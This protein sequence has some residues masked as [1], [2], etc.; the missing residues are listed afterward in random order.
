MQTLRDLLNSVQGRRFLETNGVYAIQ[1][2]FKAHLQ[3]PVNQKLAA[4]RGQDNKKL[5]CSG[6][7]IYVDYRQSVLSKIILLQELEREDD[8]YP[9]FLWVDTDR[10]GSDNL[11]TKLA[12][13]VYSKKGPIS[14]LPPRS[15]EIE[16]RFVVLDD[17]RLT[18]A[19]DKLETYLRQHSRHKKGAKER[20]LQLRSI[21]VEEDHP[22]LSQ[23]NLRLTNFL[24]NDVLEY[25]PPSLLLS[26]AI[27]QEVI[28]REIELFVNNLADVVQ[29]FN[30][31]IESLTRQGL[32]PQVTPLPENY[33]PLFFSCEV[34]DQR[35]RLY[36]HNE[37]SSYFAVGRCRCG[38]E[39]KFHLGQKDLSIALIA[40]SQRWSPDVCFPIFFNDLVSGFVAGKSSAL[41][42]MVMNQVMRRVLDKTP[43]PILVPVSLGQEND[44]S[45]EPDSLIYKYMAK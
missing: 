45:E 42:L 8:L 15:R 12:W 27:S 43:V 10:S 9:F 7:Q 3:R 29:V 31:T 32:D 6:Q 2:E 20:F 44:T 35:L 28:N 36:R 1:S 26:E 13:P 41:Y 39:Y 11:I 38:Q 17:T 14:I 30:E 34:D 4:E 24:L 19:I 40:Q 16:S 21:F 25:T 18:S 37:N 5:I 33:F 23:F 22:I